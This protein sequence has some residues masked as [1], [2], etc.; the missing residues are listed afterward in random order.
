MAKSAVI[1]IISTLIIVASGVALFLFLRTS[2]PVVELRPHYALGKV[3]AEEA[4]KL[5]GN[6]GRL[7]LFAHDPKSFN[8]PTMKAQ[9][10]SFCQQVAKAGGKIASTNL[11]ALDPLR[12]PSVPVGSFVDRMVRCTPGDVIVSLMGPPA[13]SND[14][15]RRLGDKQVKV[16]AVCSGNTPLRANLPR[17]FAQRQLHTAIVSRAAPS[18]KPASQSPDRAWFDA[19]FQIQTSETGANVASP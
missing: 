14:Q 10:D 7:I 8:F 3:V 1:R 9:L 4:L 13:L 16:L 11:V 12:I 15:I 2:Q 17:L 6:Q 5:A 19:F 18:P